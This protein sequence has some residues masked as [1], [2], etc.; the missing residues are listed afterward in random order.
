M[1]QLR[2]FVAKSTLIDNTP[3]NL[4]SVGELSS[5][6]LTYSKEKGYYAS[7]IDTTLGIVSFTSLQDDAKVDVTPDRVD[8]SA[9]ISKHIYDRT[10]N[11]PGVPTTATELLNELVQTFSAE[12]EN[13]DCGAIVEY[14]MLYMPEFVSFKIRGEDS[15]IKLW[16][17]DAAF[18][19]QFPDYEITVV[20]PFTPIDDFF[21]P[22]AQVEEKLNG[23]SRPEMSQKLQEA[24]DDYPDTYNRIYEFDYYDP[25]NSARVVPAPFGVL[26]Y[27]QMGYNLDAIKEAICDEI[28]KNSNYT[29]DQWAGI[30]P[31]LFKRR[32][33]IM[34]PNWRIFS[35]EQSQRNYGIYRS[36]MTPNEILVLTRLIATD[37][38]KAHV[39]KYAT[40]TGYPYRSLALCS[41][42]SVENANN[43]FK[44][45]DEFPDFM[46]IASTDHDFNRMSARTREWAYMLADMIYHAESFTEFSTVP[47]GYMKVVRGGRLFL[48]ANYDRVNYLV[49]CKVSL[50]RV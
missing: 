1:Y 24:K 48:Q 36:V 3:F 38:T 33:F 42:G 15:H 16:Y 49:L 21:K 32:E 27:G 19:L 30:L 13:L 18:R 34:I 9:K 7:A 17:V 2:A 8:L 28:L 23:I 12:V 6:S 4:A 25:D 29:R 40:M 35:S 11:D 39:D 22:G 10:I 37:Y 14:N 41:I 46:A 47:Q 44:I 5:W 20:L 45:T 26:I 31:D 50:P 43:K